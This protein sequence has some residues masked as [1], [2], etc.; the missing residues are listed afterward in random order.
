[1]KGHGFSGNRKPAYL[2][3]KNLTQTGRILHVE[4]YPF[5]KLLQLAFS[6]KGKYWMK[7]YGVT[8]LS[9]MDYLKKKKNNK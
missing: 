7:Q 6:G 5:R 1:M 9:N 8:R 2:F 3:F 4:I